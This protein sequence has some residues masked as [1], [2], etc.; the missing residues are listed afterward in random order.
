MAPDMRVRLEVIRAM[1]ARRRPA[2][3]PVL[4]GMLNRHEL[5]GAAR[6]AIA[7][8]EGALDF[9]DEVMG[10][11]DFARDVRVHIPRT[12]VLFEPTRAARKLMN[13]LVHE[14]D[15]AVRFKVL[16]AL[17]KLRR[18]HRKL[19]LDEAVLRTLVESTLD[20]AMQLRHWGRGLAGPD[21]AKPPAS[22]AGDPLRA[23]HHLLADLVRDKE[24][25]ATQRL[26]MLL[27]LLYG[28]DFES[29]ERGL[30]SKKPK[31]R[32]SSLELVE[33]VVRPPL[34]GRVLALVGDGDE[35][36]P[37][38]S[39][40]DTVCAV[41]TEGSTT[42]RMLAEYRAV[43]LGI[44]VASITGTR[45]SQLPT[46]E[47][48]GKRLVDRARTFLTPDTSPRGSSRAPV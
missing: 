17:V 46:I 11:A 41:L 29:I 13:H 45:P 42:M 47:S 1:A 14:K 5:R 35:S 39:Y 21:E 36:S 27:E 18:A 40:E 6:A 16:R 9:L 43:E 23:V 37:P 25:H 26:F 15:G 20:H 12:M 2:F 10:H 33:N 44:D 22:V 38:L 30:R 34:R 48:L 28:E 24:A 32:A 7:R 4:V 31:T 3:L 8:I 19:A